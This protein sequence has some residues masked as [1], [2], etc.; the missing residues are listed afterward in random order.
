MKYL[1]ATAL[2]L[3][4]TAFSVTA[5]EDG[6]V[7]PEAAASMDCE[8]SITVFQDVSRIGRKDGAAKNMTGKHKEMARTGWRFADMEVY[9]ENGDLEGFFLS[10]SRNIACDPES[11]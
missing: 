10:Y 4:I 5:Q 1:F 7:A 11:T 2:L 8:E 9:T 3:S 6:E